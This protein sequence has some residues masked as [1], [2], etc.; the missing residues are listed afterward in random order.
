MEFVYRYEKKETQQLKYFLKEQGISK[1][2]LAKV[3]FQGGKIFVNDAIQNVLYFLEEHD[4][5]RMVIPDEGE[6][7]TLVPDDTP[8]EIVFE[9]EH[10]LIINKPTGVSSIPAQYHPNKTMANRVMVITNAKGM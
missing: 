3:K 2:L 5:V 4:V 6:H 1:G 8:I 9:D 7:E 10:L